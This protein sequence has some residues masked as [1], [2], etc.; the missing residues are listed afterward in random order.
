[1]Y[2]GALEPH[3]HRTRS[4][5]PRLVAVVD[6]ALPGASTGSATD[7]SPGVTTRSPPAST[8]P[9]LTAHRGAARPAPWPTEA[10]RAPVAWPCAGGR[11]GG[12]NAQLVSPAATPTGRAHRTAGPIPPPR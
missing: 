11:R 2:S 7:G 5:G 6:G 12:R 1:M 3:Q 4:S 9:V 10:N 8:P